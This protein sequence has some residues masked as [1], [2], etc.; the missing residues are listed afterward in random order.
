VLHPDSSLAVRSLRKMSSSEIYFKSLNPLAP[1]TLLLLHG[2][3]SSHREW[4]LVSAH[5]SAY[6]LLVPDLPAHGR[7][8]SSSIPFTIPDTAA[9]LA[10]LV[11]KHA[12]NGKADFIGMSLGGYTAIYAAQKYPHV[13]GT[14]G[15]F[16]TGCGKPWSRP[17]SFMT[18]ASGLVLSLTG[19][20]LHYLPKSLF[21]W[22]CKKTGVQISDELLA[23]M[24]VASPYRLGQTV[25]RAVAEDPAN[26]ERNWRG[27][28]ERVTARTCVVAGLLDD[29]EKDCL[30]RGKQLRK[31]NPESMAFKV[32]GKRHAWDLQDPELFARGVKAWLER[33]EL[34]EEFIRL[35]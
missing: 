1:R 32:E 5:L 15:L 3:F 19:W 33:E 23:D 8:T 18:W 10:D 22:V 26:P 20:M 25:A 21:R 27:L 34:P 14:G 28:S 13:I 17:G 11:I 6:H 2:A 35:W 31:G 29:G 24:K 9:L 30:E 12:K 16:L 7:S 4:D